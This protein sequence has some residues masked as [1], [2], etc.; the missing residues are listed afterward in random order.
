MGLPGLA[1]WS[2]HAAAVTVAMGVVAS[3]GSLVT[4]YPLYA[5]APLPAVQ[6][7]ATGPFPATPVRFV[8]SAGDDPEAVVTV[9]SSTRE[10][11]WSVIANCSMMSWPAMSCA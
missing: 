6:E 8:G 5:V 11:P 3:R 4:R 2:V 1:R 10:I 7:G 9:S